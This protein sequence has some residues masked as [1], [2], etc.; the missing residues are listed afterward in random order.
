VLKPVGDDI[1]GDRIVT[2]GPVTAEALARH[3]AAQVLERERAADTWTETGLV[4]T[5]RTG[6]WVDPSNVGRLMDGLI[7]GA[8]VP[9][10]PPKGLR[11]TTWYVGRELVGDDRLIDE[12]L[13]RAEGDGHDLFATL[14][15]PH[16]AAGL[17]LD[18]AFAPSV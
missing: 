3:R 1:G 18:Q 16:R 9:R 5:T 14:S 17:R 2:F 11:Q 6:G 15:E 4:F 12:R 8:G 10:I 7:D 13:G